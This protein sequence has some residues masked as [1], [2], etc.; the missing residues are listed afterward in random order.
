[1]RPPKPLF[2]RTWTVGACVAFS[3]A[4]TV[5]ALFVL[6][7]LA[8]LVRAGYWSG[9][10]LV[11]ALGALLLIVHVSIVDRVWGAVSHPGW[12]KDRLGWTAVALHAVT[13]IIY[14]L[15]GLASVVVAWR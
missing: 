11:V 14:A 6:L 8:I 5:A 15:G 2:G 3:A 13:V 10:S 9:P 7:L 4:V 12:T 1:M